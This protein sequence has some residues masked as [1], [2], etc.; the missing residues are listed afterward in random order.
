MH[1]VFILNQRY[2]VVGDQHGRRLV[3][4]SRHGLLST[5]DGRC[6][7][8]AAA[9]ARCRQCG[10]CRRVLIIIDRLACITPILHA[11]SL[12][13]RTSIRSARALYT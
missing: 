7:L 10:M 11:P 4:Y 8:H 13:V 6:L 3:A 1:L 9:A 5:G 12:W 2:S